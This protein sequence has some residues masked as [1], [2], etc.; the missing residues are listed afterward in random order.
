MA[1]RI[2]INVYREPE[3]IVRQLSET[4]HPLPF[5]SSSSGPHDQMTSFPSLM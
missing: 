3:T 5:D 2:I 4:I 1:R